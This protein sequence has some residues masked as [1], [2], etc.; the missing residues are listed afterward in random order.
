VRASD[1]DPAGHVNNAVHWAAAED[2]LAGLGWLPVA[3]ELEYRRPIV[4][5]DSPQLLVSEAADVVLFWLVN[6]EGR[7]ASGRLARPGPAASP[8]ASG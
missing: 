1:F 2:V 8:P 7:L 3:A 6:G 5:G 4:P